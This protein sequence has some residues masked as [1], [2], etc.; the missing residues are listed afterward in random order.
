MLYF[1]LDRQNPNGIVQFILLEAPNEIYSEDKVLQ[2][3]KQ[4]HVK[5][6]IVAG[7][8]KYDRKISKFIQQQKEVYKVGPYI[9]FE[10]KK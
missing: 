4:H 8:Y 2:E 3:I 5:Y 1:V 9:V 7:G 10:I 6:V